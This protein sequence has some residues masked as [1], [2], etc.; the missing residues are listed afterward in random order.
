MT[1]LSAPVRLRV[2]FTVRGAAGGASHVHGVEGG[3]S[4]RG[5]EKLRRRRDQPAAEHI[6]GSIAPDGVERR[7]V[8]V[9]MSSGF[10]LAKI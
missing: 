10:G 8:T 9:S 7:V 2:M 6:D 4:D 1:S 3:A 5:S